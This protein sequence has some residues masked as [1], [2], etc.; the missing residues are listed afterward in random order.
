MAEKPD[1]R[2]IEIYLDALEKRHY[3]ASLRRQRHADHKNVQVC[4][5]VCFF[6]F[7]FASLLDGHPP[8]LVHDHTDK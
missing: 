8:D 4:A 2:V 7:N 6:V 5:P 3:A 1:R